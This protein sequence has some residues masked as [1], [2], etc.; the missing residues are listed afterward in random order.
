[1]L[2]ATLEIRVRLLELLREGV[3]DLDPLPV[4]VS[5]F[6]SFARGE[7]NADSDIDLLLVTATDEG[8]HEEQWVSR[9]RRFE[10]QVFAAT[11]NRL[12]PLVLSAEAMGKA[13]RAGEPIVE[14][15]V[16]DSVVLFGPTFG[17][18]VKQEAAEA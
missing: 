10:D 3:A 17:Q 5:I 16:A 6:G 8:R 13:I 2:L 12:E 4:H 14:S 7:G 1:M 11:G 9:L 18:L 15:L